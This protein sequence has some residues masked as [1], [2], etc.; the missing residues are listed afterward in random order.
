MDGIHRAR[1][2][3]ALT[4]SIVTNTCG[5]CGRAI[6]AEVFDEHVREHQSKPKPP[7]SRGLRA[8]CA[9]I[10]VS[11]V[12]LFVAS[13]A[14]LGA[15]MTNTVSRSELAQI[16][17]Y[18]VLMLVAVLAFD[19]SLIAWWLR[20]RYGWHAVALSLGAALLFLVLAERA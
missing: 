12:A 3:R 20:W 8:S 9:G 11:V 14:A 6:G 2:E 4:A 7:P 16:S 5:L 10:V 18:L 15:T 19:L 17:R 13:V 1:G